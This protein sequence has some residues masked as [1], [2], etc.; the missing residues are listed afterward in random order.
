[1]FLNSN[2]L[3]NLIYDFVEHVR[4]LMERALEPE[5]IREDLAELKVLVVFMTKRNRQIVGGRI[6]TGEITKGTQIEVFRE[7]EKVGEGRVINLQMNKREIERG[8]RGDEVGILYEGSVQIEKGDTLIIYK[9]EKK[10][11]GL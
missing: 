2:K 6:T 7:E 9:E 10:K 8:V 11:T 4:R 1:M 3:F 5:L